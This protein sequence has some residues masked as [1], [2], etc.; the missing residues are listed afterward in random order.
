M[1]NAYDLIKGQVSGY[2]VFLVLLAS[3]ILIFVDRRELSRKNLKKE[4]KFAFILGCIY[5]LI[6]IGIGIF[7]LII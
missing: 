6:A 2:V 5:L 1:G 7:I 4:S 3:I